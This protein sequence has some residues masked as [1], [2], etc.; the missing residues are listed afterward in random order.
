MRKKINRA[1]VFCMLFTLLTGCTGGAGSS[2]VVEVQDTAVETT[3]ETTVEQEVTDNMLPNNGVEVVTSYIVIEDE[4]SDITEVSIVTDA[5]G[6][7]SEVIM[8]YEYCDSASFMATTSKILE[9]AKDCYMC[10]QTADIQGIRKAFEMRN[11]LVY[12][13][14]EYKTKWSAGS[15]T[16]DT[17]EALLGEYY[18]LV[19][20]YTDIFLKLMDNR[21]LYSNNEEEQENIIAERIAMNNTLML[22]TTDIEEKIGEIKEKG[23]VE[24]FNFELDI[25][26]QKELENLNETEAV[27]VTQTIEE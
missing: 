20:N 11:T 8:T 22:L 24:D 26:S 17:G 21:S 19:Y 1:V 25:L 7:E 16:G 10:Y 18:T 3:I 14:T 9:I 5:E 4:K 12:Y 27:T 13:W 15:V 2:E 23:I 6:V